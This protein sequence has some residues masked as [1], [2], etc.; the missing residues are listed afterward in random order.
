MKIWTV[1]L[2]LKIVFLTARDEE[3][4]KNHSKYDELLSADRAEI[5]HH[6]K[7]FEQSLRAIDRNRP[8]DTEIFPGRSAPLSQRVL[9]WSLCKTDDFCTKL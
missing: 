4:H 3:M 5:G 2:S 7:F 8:K 1:G 6:S 9:N